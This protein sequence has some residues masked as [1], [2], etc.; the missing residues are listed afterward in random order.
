MCFSKCEAES[1]SLVLYLEVPG[2]ALEPRGGERVAVGQHLVRL[3]EAL[4]HPLLRTDHRLH[5]LRT[6]SCLCH[7]VTLIGYT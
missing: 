3:L 1:E 6:A 2:G 4:Q 7:D 5:I